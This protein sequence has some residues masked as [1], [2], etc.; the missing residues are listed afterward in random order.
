[1]TGGLAAPVIAAGMGAAVALAGGGAAGA[2]VAGAAGR[3]LSVCI[4]ED[5]V[6]SR[7]M[8][9]RLLGV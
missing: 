5:Q 7:F 2:V 4:G 1:M 3:G 9:F 6:R 8:Y